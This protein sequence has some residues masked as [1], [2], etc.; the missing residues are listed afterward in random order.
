MPYKLSLMIQRQR[1]S[2]RFAG[3]AALRPHLGDI[4]F[5]DAIPRHELD[6]PVGEGD[7][8]ERERSAGLAGYNFLVFTKLD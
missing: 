3:Q 2:N 6:P 8:K 4:P 1:L 5:V 7:H